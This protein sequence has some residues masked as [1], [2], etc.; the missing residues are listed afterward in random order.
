MCLSV[1]PIH[2]LSAP[3][4][5]FNYHAQTTAIQTRLGLPKA[6]QVSFELKS[7]PRSLQQRGI[8]ELAGHLKQGRRTAAS[9]TTPLRSRPMRRAKTCV[10]LARD[11]GRLGYLA[12][13]RGK[14]PR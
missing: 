2:K 6:V 4:K 7:A 12:L 9:S 10:P 1:N 13:D 8:R 3:I 11:S 14:R 5:P